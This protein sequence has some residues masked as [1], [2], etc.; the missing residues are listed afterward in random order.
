MDKSTLRPLSPVEKEVLLSFIEDLLVV[1]R[2]IQWEA[3]AVHENSLAIFEVQGTR[4]RLANL[5]DAAHNLPH[6]F[7][8]QA[9][10]VH[11]ILR[12]IELALNSDVEAVEYTSYVQKLAHK[13]NFILPLRHEL[14]K[15]R[16]NFSWLP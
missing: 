5:Y 11:L 9:V 7:G 13:M 8:S 10:N 12:N 1:S 6:L 3:G 15:A 14:L 16:L 2:S 4:E